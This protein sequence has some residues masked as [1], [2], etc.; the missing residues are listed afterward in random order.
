MAQ[1]KK[2]VRVTEKGVQSAGNMGQPGV[3]L[4]QR[5][6]TGARKASVDAL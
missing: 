3:A 5:A 4:G 6:R 1:N 2:M